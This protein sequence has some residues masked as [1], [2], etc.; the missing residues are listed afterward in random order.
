MIA[1]DFPL[2]HLSTRVPWHDTGWTGVICQA[3]HL[4][5]A[6]AKLRRIADQK[7]EDP[8]YQGEQLTGNISGSLSARTTTS[9]LGEQTRM[10]SSEWRAPCGR[11]WRSAWHACDNNRIEQDRFRLAHGAAPH[12]EAFERLRLGH[13]AHVSL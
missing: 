7:K 5:G 6:R 1:S 11:R 8:R 9:R 10:V 3:P 13:L 2:R 12:P 4:N